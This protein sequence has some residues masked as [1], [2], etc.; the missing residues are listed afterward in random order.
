MRGL[1]NYF[2]GMFNGIISLVKGMGVTGK[3]FFTS[4]VTIVTQQYPENRKTLEMFDAFKGEV[5]MPHDENNEH[6]CTACSICQINCPNGSIEIVS[7]DVVNEEGKK[8]KELD[9][10]LYN[11]GMCSFCGL[12]IKT[13][14]SNAL[15]WGQEFEHSMFTRD[16]F[17]K[18]LNNEGSKL[19]QKK[20]VE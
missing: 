10:H 20:G 14:P 17:V 13:C 18:T 5:T 9:K 1:I 3:Y 12:C 6:K 15:A 19:M 2:S 8:R 4:P 11:I 16:K 7:R